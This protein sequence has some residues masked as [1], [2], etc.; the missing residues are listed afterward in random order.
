M[1]A[2]FGKT[3]I[4]K[5]LVEEGSWADLFVPAADGCNSMHYAAALGHR[6]LL[7]YLVSAKG[8]SDAASKINSAGLTPLA[9]A[10]EGNQLECAKL[11]LSQGAGRKRADAPAGIEP[12]H[13]AAKMGALATLMY[14]VELNPGVLEERNSDGAT[15]VHY[16]ASAGQEGALAYIVGK[17][18]G[19]SEAARAQAMLDDAGRT[20]AHHAASN[21]Q[22]GSLRVLS[23]RNM[24]LSTADKTGKTPADV[25]RENDRTEC[26]IFLALKSNDVHALLKAGGKEM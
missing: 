1:A 18:G 6:E 9:K 13:A 25:A 11:M 2:L 21:G 26:A 15:V 22:Q 12:G 14:L 19:L 5:W 10:A 8:G 20:A 16:A 4:L 23:D 7:E 17:L 3:D 24:A